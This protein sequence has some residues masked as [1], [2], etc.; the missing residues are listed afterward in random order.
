MVQKWQ[1]TSVDP[2][3]DSISYSISSTTKV[4]LATGD[5]HSQVICEVAHVT[6]QG[7]SSPWDC[8]LVRDHPR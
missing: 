3:G 1:L 8:Q 2:E 6:L 4:L 7:A 5:V